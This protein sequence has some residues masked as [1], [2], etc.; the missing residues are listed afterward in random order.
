MKCKILYLLVVMMIGSGI[1]NAVS[2]QQKESWLYTKLNNDASP[3]LK[4]VLTDPDQYRVQ[5]IYTR[6]DRDKNNKPHFTSYRLFKKDNYFYP[7]ST[8]KLPT[9]LV[10]LEKLNE[11]H[12]AGLDI[13][14][15][16]ITD[17]AYTHQLK[18]SKDSSAMDMKPSIAQ[19]IKKIF[20]VSDNDAYNRLYEFDGQHYL[21]EKLQA[22]GYKDTRIVHRFQYPMTEEEN[23]HTNP[24]TFFNNDQ[25]IYKQPAA[26][27][28]QTIPSPDP[29]L[30]GNKH[31]DANEVLKD[32]PM[33]FSH[34]NNF[35][36]AEQ[37]TMLRTVLF[38]ESVAKEKRFNLT[39]E[40]YSF[41]YK[42]MSM[43]PGESEDPKYDKKEFFDTYAKF[44]IYRS[45][46][47]QKPDYM[48][49]FSK[50]GWSHGFLTDNAYIIDT[51]NK[52]EFMVS[53]TIYVNSDGIVNDDKYDYDEK[54]YPFFKEVGEILYQHELQRTRKFKPDFSK[55]GL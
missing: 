53:A 20:V 18:V 31:V 45:D 17:S 9:V 44:F 34:K 41:V 49:I 52:V 12:V 4:E 47:K 21:N 24:I 38:P 26:Y 30:I 27:N 5:V 14:A 28:E 15:T 22:K 25:L 33:D 11:L 19:Y 36:L 55:F 16:M 32:G 23:K 1:N 46:K 50:A 42:Y 3:A 39:K 48:R 54:G 40:D 8:V 7:A 6:I 10:A 35:P 29:I 2:S 43:M 37:Q 13:H 51:K